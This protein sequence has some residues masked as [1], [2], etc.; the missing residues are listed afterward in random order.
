[1]KPLSSIVI[2]ICLALTCARTCS[3]SAADVPQQ[4][5]AAND[6]TLKQDASP[7]MPVEQQ[8]TTAKSD[9]VELQLKNLD[10]HISAVSAKLDRKDYTAAWLGLGGTL[11]GAIVAALVAI[12]T[13]HLRARQDRELASERARLE[14][15]TSFV[16]WHLKQLSELYGPLHALL[17]QSQSLYRHMNSV[18]IGKDGAKFRMQKS[19]GTDRIDGKVFE[20]CIGNEWVRFRTVLHISEV[21]DCG[22]GVEDY[23]DEISDIG[24][25]MVTVIREK[26]GYALPEQTDLV[27]LFGK[28]LAHQ[29]VLERLVKHHKTLAGRATQA[30]DGKP[31]STPPTKDGGIN[32]D[33]SAVFPGEIQGIVATGY[34]TIINELNAWRQKAGSVTILTA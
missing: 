1:M 28:Y 31:V 22:Y 21:Y 19:A 24:G 4:A 7:R 10:V 14:I 32:V 3:G 34:Q 16:E 6:P 8:T 33:E 26:A 18:L 30:A 15:N 13:Q 25:R 27:P 17:Q 12:L 20:I 9:Q 23:F 2:A 5:A 11:V 29:A